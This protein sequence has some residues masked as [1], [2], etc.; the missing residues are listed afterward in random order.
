[1]H[2]NTKIT[3]FE[4]AHANTHPRPHAYLYKQTRIITHPHSHPILATSLSER[5]REKNSS[6]GFDAPTLLINPLVQLRDAS[7]R[8]VLHAYVF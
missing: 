6:R 2:I 1:M 3:A 4:N 5:R 7:A 8:N